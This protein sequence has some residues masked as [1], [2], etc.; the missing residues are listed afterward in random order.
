[1]IFGWQTA[2]LYFIGYSSELHPGEIESAG[3]TGTAWDFAGL[4]WGGLNV[5][6][7]RKKSETEGWAVALT[8]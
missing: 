2:Y 5:S 7:H 6:M 1:M 4:P 8:A 3:N